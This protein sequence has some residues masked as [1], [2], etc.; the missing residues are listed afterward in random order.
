METK[1]INYFPPLRKNFFHGIESWNSP[2]I[3]E[4]MSKG[5]FLSIKSTKSRDLT[6]SPRFIRNHIEVVHKSRH[7]FQ[8][9]RAQYQSPFK[10]PIHLIPLQDYE[11]ESWRN[12]T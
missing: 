12:L 1:R 9:I 7:S 5:S 3:K 11:L 6:V 10:T 2:S 4:N 8:P